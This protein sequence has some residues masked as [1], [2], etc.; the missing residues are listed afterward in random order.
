MRFGRVRFDVER[1]D[2]A[3]K[4]TA[5]TGPPEWVKKGPRKAGRNSLLAAAVSDDGRYLAVGGGDKRVHVWDVR[6]REHIQ[7]RQSTTCQACCSCGN[8]H[9]DTQ[10]SIFHPVLL[11]TV[12]G[13]AERAA[14]GARNF[15]VLLPRS[16]QCDA[17]SWWMRRASRAT[18]ILCRDWPSARA[19]TS[20]SAPPLIARS[21]HGAWTIARMWT[22]CW[23]TR[24]KCCQ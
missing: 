4:D 7:V 9:I 8:F 11:H 18:E 12:L 22:L 19:P 2:D 13:W 1:A 17:F 16:W 23:G 5:D 6:S 3:V 10:P 14:Q 15:Q 21:R 20:S 24:A